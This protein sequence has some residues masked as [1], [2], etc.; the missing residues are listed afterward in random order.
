VT[1]WEQAEALLAAMEAAFDADG[2]PCVRN[3]VSDGS[4]VFDF[5]ET[6]AVEWERNEPWPVVGDGSA[7]SPSDFSSGIIAMQSVFSIIVMRH[8]PWPDEV[9]TPPIPSVI[10]AN[11]EIVHADALR[12]LT[13]LSTAIKDGV[14]GVCAQVTLYNQQMFGP[15][16]GTVGSTTR[17]A[18]A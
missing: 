13:A 2:A 15:D 4:V 12:V 9:G 6:L 11:A 8:T 1:P 3:Y 10:H 16:G 17:I 7:S 14:F 5:D 18:I